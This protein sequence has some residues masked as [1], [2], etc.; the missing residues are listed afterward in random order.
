MMEEGGG[1]AMARME[2]RA[3]ID[4][5]PKTLSFH[6]IKLAREAALDVVNTCTVEEALRIFTETCCMIQGLEPIICCGNGLDREEEPN[7]DENDELRLPQ[8]LRD[9]ISAPF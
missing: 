8:S 5:E 2:G 4:G 3:S 7:E 1:A 9:V 6:Q